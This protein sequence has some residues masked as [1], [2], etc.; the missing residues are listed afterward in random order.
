MGG[1]VPRYLNYKGAIFQITVSCK[2]P[3]HSNIFSK[4]RKSYKSL[5]HANDMISTL[6]ASKEK[7]MPDKHDIPWFLV[8]FLLSMLVECMSAI[9]AE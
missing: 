5:Y 4:K 9:L 8:T 1:N 6:G 7:E 3:L 2:A